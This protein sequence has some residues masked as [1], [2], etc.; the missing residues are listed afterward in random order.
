MPSPPTYQNNSS[1]GSVITT[2]TGEV[3]Q[4]FDNFMPSAWR[5]G[6]MHLHIDRHVVKV[7]KTIMLN[8]TT[9]EE[10][11]G[12]DLLLDTGTY[13]WCTGKNVYI[14]AIIEGISVSCRGFSDNL[15]VEENLPVVNIIYAYDYK[16][17]GEVILLQPNHCIYFGNRK[18]DAIVCPN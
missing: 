11:N 2:S 3:G 6:G 17:R 4:A 9:M 16:K 1:G 10:S 15:P 5:S 13:T 8:I 14:L 18:N 12:C 7:T